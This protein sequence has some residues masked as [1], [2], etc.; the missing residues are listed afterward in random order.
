L[1]RKHFKTLRKGL[2]TS[3]HRTKKISASLKFLHRKPEDDVFTA[4]MVVLSEGFT[5]FA[6][7][8]YDIRFQN[9]LR[10]IAGSKDD[11][12]LLKFLTAALGSR[13][14]QY[15]AFHSGSSN[16][17]G[18]DKLHLYES[19]SLAFPL[20]NH[21]LAAENANE[22]VQ[23]AAAIFKE[24]ERL[25][26]KADAE[27]RAEL[28]KAATA[29]LEPLV[30]A[31]YRV[32]DAERILIED[33]LTLWQPSIHSHNLDKPVPSLAFPTL[34]DRKRYADTLCDVLNRRARKQGIRIRTESMA[35]KELNL[36]FFTVI[37]GNESKPHRDAGGDDELWKALKRVDEAAQRE[38]GPF[39]YLRG[40]NYFKHDRL[41][42]LKP[43]T[44]RNWSRTSALN[45]ADAIFEHLNTGNT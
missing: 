33:T 26:K 7:C 15:L 41:Y 42:M 1:E 14:M 9:S 28:V 29:K 8:K 19:L 32:T 35:S 20:P 36:V 6:F 37:F 34:A 3:I 38:N 17:I 5:K 11:A 43:A 24:V 25:G 13:L 23:K 4:P 44:M 10:S 2:E 27:K 30:E 18:R 45:D 40:F 21:E 22:I 31:Y 16:G 39:N 12:E